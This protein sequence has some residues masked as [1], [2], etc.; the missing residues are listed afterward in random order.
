MAQTAVTNSI[1]S[2]G[3]DIRVA[4][5]QASPEVSVPPVI[6]TDDAKILLDHFAEEG[7]V[8]K[9]DREQARDFQELVAG[10]NQATRDEPE[11]ADFARVA[12]F[13]N[14]EYKNGVG[15]IG[16]D[17]KLVASV[18]ECMLK[19]EK[20][21]GYPP[22]PAAEIS[23]KDAQILLDGFE[24]KQ[25]LSKT[26]EEQKIEF[27]NMLSRI[28]EGRDGQAERLAGELKTPGISDRAIAETRA[29]IADLERLGNFMMQEYKAGCSWKQDYPVEKFIEKLDNIANPKVPAAVPTASDA[30]TA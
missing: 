9:N 16:D 1:D 15:K 14:N 28:D 4:Q 29:T 11:N 7:T 17:G 6:T 22:Q 27:R 10:F 3:S 2:S 19:L 12:N 20:A 13:L 18:V 8:Y 23:A 30:K 24:S 26:P 21:A 25:T 5:N